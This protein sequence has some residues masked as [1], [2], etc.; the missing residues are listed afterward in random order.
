MAFQSVRGRQNFPKR[1]N[2]KTTIGGYEEGIHWT[3]RIF[4]ASNGIL[5]WVLFDHGRNKALFQKVVWILLLSLIFLESLRLHSVYINQLA[6]R[7]FYP[8]MRKNETKRLSGMGYYLAGILFASYFESPIVF[9]IAILHLA[10]GD[11]VAAI[12]GLLFCCP[13]RPHWVLKSGKN[14]SGLLA[15]WLICML[16]TLS[17]LYLQGMRGLGFWLISILSSLV[18]ALVESCTPTPQ[19]I[20]PFFP[21]SFFP[22][23]LDDNLLIPLI[24]SIVVH[25]MLLYLPFDYICSNE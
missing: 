8:I 19:Y 23:G 4:H 10:I 21:S 14:V 17:Y 20:L 9:E 7:L 12:F 25:R 16:S 6:S 18:T 5:A 24:T 22:I 3:R 1:L 15:C 2:R 11:P 13:K